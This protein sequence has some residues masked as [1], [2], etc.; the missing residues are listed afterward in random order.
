RSGTFGTDR[1][2]LPRHCGAPDAA[3]RRSRTRRPPRQTHSI[4][5]RLLLGRLGDGPRLGRGQVE[6]AHIAARAAGLAAGRRTPFAAALRRHERLGNTIVAVLAVAGLAAFG[7]TGAAPTVSLCR[8][9]DGPHRGALE[10]AVLWRGVGRCT[11]ADG[12][13]HG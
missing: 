2:G 13:N 7:G 8:H 3:R 11:E 4:S 1:L 10:R 12:Q 6:L 9:L 5:A